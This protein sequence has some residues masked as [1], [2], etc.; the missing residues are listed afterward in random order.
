MDA[1]ALPETEILLNAIFRLQTFFSMVH[2]CSETWKL[3]LQWPMTLD[4]DFIGLLHQLNPGALAVFAHWCVPVN[5][6]PRKWVTGDFAARAVGNIG[7]R[8]EGTVWQEALAWPISQVIC[9]LDVLD[10]G[11]DV[12][13]VM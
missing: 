7:R 5:F 12:H 4:T 9:V 10:M 3:I 13:F 1:Q 2:P 11:K 6:A 8:L